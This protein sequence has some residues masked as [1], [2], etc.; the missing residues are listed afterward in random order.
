MGHSL[1]VIAALCLS[2]LGLPGASWIP[3]NAGLSN[4]FF[5]ITALT[6]D[7]LAPSTV[8]GIA[9]GGGLFKSTDG[10][11]SWKAVAGI[12]GLSFLAIDPTNSATIYGATQHGVVKS[13]DDGG[14]WNPANGDLT[15]NLFSLAIDP[16]TPTTVYGLSVGYISKTTDGGDTWKRI[17]AS[18]PSPGSLVID[19]TTP[20]T[21]Y[22]SI[23]NADIIKSIDGGESWVTIKTGLP[24]PPF[25]PGE[26]ALVIDPRTPS[27][28]YAGSFAS[29]R[30][31]MAPGVPPLYYGTGTISKSTDGGQ[32]W[33]TVTAGIPSEALVSSLA[34]DPVTPSTIYGA[35]T[36][37][38][39]GGGILK[40]VDGGQ[41]WS[42]IDTKGFNNAIAAVDLRTPSTIYAAYSS[43]DGTGTI[44]KSA[45][46]GSSWQPS[47]EG[48]V[49]RNFYTLAI[50]PVNAG[51][52]YG[53]GADGVFRSDDA[54]GS[55]MNLAAFHFTAFF[56]ATGAVRSLLV[57][58]KNPDI[59]YAETTRVGGCAFDDNTVF[60]STDRGAT[61]SDSV[62]PPGSGCDLGGYD[63]YS[64][65]M[66]MDPVN[67]DTLYL[68]ETE[69]E[70]GIYALLKSTDGGASWSS[71]WDDTNGL[72]SGL[73]TLAIDP[74]TPT[75]L[76]AGVG[77]SGN[78]GESGSAASGVFKSTDGGASWNVT[79]LK[80]TAV[81]VL[82][83]DPT[84]ASTLYAVS[85]GIYSEPTGFRGLFKS[86]DGGASWV[87]IGAGL[88]NLAGVGATITAIVINPNNSRAV[89]AATSG[90]GIYRSVDGGGS[91][92]RFSDGLTNLNVRALAIV[93]GAQATLYAATP[94]GVF[95]AVDDAL[96]AAFK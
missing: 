90:D 87:T 57:N 3:V 52:V 39:A 18:P 56:P 28:L 63:A 6:V 45:D 85:Q 17:H 9:S 34:I 46:A 44:S 38:N 75:T 49:Y 61:W 12:A 59:L 19:P 11:A 32:T 33:M 42:V 83:I 70:D 22:A 71:I 77:D 1:C 8:Y 92:T 73:N 79:T 48:L 72:E 82:T 36:S 47:N 20:S 68:G 81:T 31:S 86:T 37:E 25:S 7:P 10:A 43:Y 65:L 2:C 88:D 53:G 29:S 96:T 91:W 5:G 51:R 69:D 13:T 62:S 15:D 94:G 80:D 84:K 74:F 64:I 26:L 50:D 93:P 24:T 89:Y 4:S 23:I 67:P 78:Y 16:V 41:S 40:S 66:A 21:I 58:F 55:W 60:K 35:Y 54:G 76:Y 30:V 95:R 27:T 14:T